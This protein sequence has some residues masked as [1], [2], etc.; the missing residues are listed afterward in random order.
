[1]L[2]LAI[3]S[4]FSWLQCLFDISLSLWVLWVLYFSFF[5]LSGTTR[6]CKIIISCHRP[7]LVICATS[8][9]SFHWRMESKTNIFELGVLTGTVL[10]LKT[11]SAERTRKYVCVLTHV[12]MHI[13]KYFCMYLRVCILS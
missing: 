3:G 7:K 6:Y 2:T 1:M 5:L 8:L 4:S 9:A 13:Y 10:L 12:Y 11:L